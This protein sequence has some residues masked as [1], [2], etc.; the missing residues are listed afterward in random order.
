MTPTVT[1]SITQADLIRQLRK[2]TEPCSIAMGN[3]VDIWQMGLI[4]GLE[5]HDGHVRVTLCLTDPGCV[6][7]TA[8][9]RFI[10]DVLRELPGV[11][12]VEV[13]QTTQTLWTPDRIRH[14]P[15]PV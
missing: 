1:S 5:L 15:L 6:H 3:P 7:L 9:R 2:V 14:R 13:C 10:T 4:E 11:E 8:M 12:S